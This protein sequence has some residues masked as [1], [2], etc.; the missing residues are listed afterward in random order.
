MVADNTPVIVGVGQFVERLDSADY[1]GLSPADI[2]ARAAEA[3]L[4]DAGLPRGAVEAVGAVRT[5]EDS[6]PR[7]PAPFGKPDKYTLAVAKRLGFTPRIAILEKGG[8]QSPLTVIMDLAERVRAGKVRAGLAFGSEAISTVRHLSAR[9][10]TRDWAETLEGAMEDHGRGLEGMVTGYNMSHGIIGAPAA[11]A[12]LENA[13]RGRL[14]M[15]REDYACE[16]GRLFAPFTQVAAANP[17]SSAASAPMSAEEIATVSERNRMIAEPYRL[18]MVSRDQVNQG[19]AV[20]VTSVAEARAAGIPEDC[21]IFIHGAGLAVE[22]DLPSRMDPGTYPA[23]E[24]ALTHVLKTAGRTAAD[25]AAFDFYSCFPTAVFTAAVDVLG[26][27]PDDPRGLT[28]TG[29]LP[30]FGGPGNNYSM[31]AIAA[32][33]GRLRQKPGS[34]G[35]VGLN[36]GMQTKYGALVLS[37]A[38]AEWPGLAAESLQE[39]RDEM[40]RPTVVRKP[41]GWGRVVTYTVTY[42]KGAPPL[43]IVIGEL[44]TGERFLANNADAVTLER[45]V[46]EDPLGARIFV[47]AR[48]EGNR[49]AFDRETIRAVF[50]RQKPVFAE[51][52]EFVEMRREGHLLEVTINRPEARN[53]LPMKA[54]HEMSS[55]FDAFEAD[56]ELWVAIVTGAG[57]KAFCA[58]ADLKTAGRGDRTMPAGGFA[59]LTSRTKAKPV[60]AAVNG[61]AFGGGFETALACDLV[62]ADPK[63]TFALSEVRVGLFAGAGGIIRLPRQLPRKLAME[64]LLTG[65]AIDAATLQH[66]GFVNRISEPG[67]A[68]EAARALAQEILAA[69]PTSVRLTLQVLRETEAIADADEAARAALATPATDTLM[70]SEDMLEGTTAFAQKRPPQWKNR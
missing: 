43:G 52:Y 51:S 1:Q 6:S 32:M 49:F 45:M 22:P 33:T 2:A 13:R 28:M 10:E 27:S 4:A 31:H 47:T 5:F 61:F 70:M 8:G 59:G 19:A 68:L 20:V 37:T 21:W 30:F 56:P 14:G 48:N 53:S 65:R 40:P 17:Y 55:V 16:M 57:D 38:P 54:H 34:F 67:Q 15:S 66:Y 63:A 64:L 58:G 29:G 24:L 7:T 35:L 44:D 12:L 36:G 39:L 42:N 18:K 23:A 60:I 26:L 11:Y 41:E 69:S 46:A 3:A 50:P 25:M 9:G 62:V